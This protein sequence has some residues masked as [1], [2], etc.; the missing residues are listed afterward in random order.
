MK[1]QKDWIKITPGDS[2]AVALHELQKGRLEEVDRKTIM[3]LDDIPFGHKFA[4]KDIKK[5]ENII[6]YGMP[7]GHALKDIPCGM[8]VHTHN[9]RTNLND[10]IS[11]EYKKKEKTFLKEDPGKGPKFNGYVRKNGKVG[12]RNDIWIVPTVGC[13]NETARNLVRMAKDKYA[14]RVDD[15][16]AITHNMGCSQLGDD[17]ETTQKILA[18]IINNPNAGGVLVLSLGCENNNLEAFKPYLGDIDP[19]RVKF[20]VTQD[21]ED[22]YE[23]GLALIN[24]LM[25]YASQFERTSVGLDQ[26][27]LGFKC[28]GSDAFSGV[29]AN[30]L[31]GRV[32]DKIVAY[33]G[34]SILT[35]VP[36][37][38][39]AEVLLMER[40]ENEKVFTNIVDLINNY[41]KYFQKYGQTIYE[42]PS[43]GNKKGGISTLEEKSLGCVQKGGIAPIAGVLNYGESIKKHGLHL[44]TGSG[45]DQVSCTN[46]IASGATL[47]IFTTGRGNPF[48]TLVPTVKVSS[49]TNLYGRK[50]HWIDFDAGIIL[51]GRSF[52]QV[53][54]E[55][56]Q[57][58]IEIASGRL[59]T[60][61]E[62]FGYKD[63]SI[64]RDGVIL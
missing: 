2:V 21:V 44:L 46:L 26:L 64:F 47:I 5:G 15:I 42:N 53:T 28:G 55:F 59:Q 18:G 12:V 9:L 31:C 20:L 45:N 50:K 34:N 14:G 48:G 4:I 29:T 3:L 25:D 23:V 8:H 10:I 19:Q 22:E 27:T 13:I 39:G 35:E 61:N 6:K 1:K 38:F 11:Y 56:L 54:E 37:M 60:K 43:P 16:V 51:E 17:Q 49:N 7:I 58:I 57:Q 36:E 41:K 30:A 33:G 40:A 52:E 32:S 62:K 63:I 24:E